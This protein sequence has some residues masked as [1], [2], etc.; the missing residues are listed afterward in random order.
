MPASTL[1]AH[2]LTLYATVRDALGFTSADDA[3]VQ[4]KLE[5]IINAVSDEMA[6]L[7]HR[8]FEYGAAIVEKQRGYDDVRMVLDRAPLKAITSIEWL[9]WDGSS[10]STFAA[11][12]YEIDEDGLSGM[13]YRSAGFAWTAQLAGDILGSPMAGTE[14]AAYRVTYAGGWVTPEQ[15][16]LDAA[17]L[18]PLGWVRDLPYDLEEACI[19]SAIAVYR[20]SGQDR[21][22]LAETSAGG[23]SV[24]YSDPL[25]QAG[26]ASMLTAEA[27]RIVQRYWRGM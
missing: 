7:A 2:A 22:V 10:V 20:K 9:S 12:S 17:L 24:A 27:Q 14:R 23:S 18:V 21:S 16:R 15:A 1:S 19:Q 11:T 5:R 13:I 8:T 6:S 26:S 3:T 4:A 25:A